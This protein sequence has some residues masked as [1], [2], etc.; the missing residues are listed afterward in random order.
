MENVIK[1]LG[2]DYEGQP[3]KNHSYIVDLGSDEEFGK[4][5]STLET[6]E[7][8]EQLEDNTLLTVH[9]ASLLYLYK[10]KYQINLKSN[11]DTEEYS[12]IITDIEEL[13]NDKRDNNWFR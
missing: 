6:N 2:L 8:V 12:I 9:N 3:G 13:D 1:E 5:Y 10:D 11:F 7:D 4:V